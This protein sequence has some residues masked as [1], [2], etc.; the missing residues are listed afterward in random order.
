M[1][2]KKVLAKH[3][4]V[5]VAYLFGSI[6]RGEANEKSDMDIGI[7][8]EKG[9]KP[10]RFYEIKLAG[11]IERETGVKKVEVTILNNKPISFLN[12]VL[13]Y[14]KVIFSS[15]ERARVN[16]ETTVTKKYIDLKPYF[17][18]YNKMRKL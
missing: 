6:A 9:F 16:F 8:L 17:E 13:R 1:R 7:L 12:Q 18:E 10:E 5:L 15:D 11:E 3:R 14:G 4:E 2:I